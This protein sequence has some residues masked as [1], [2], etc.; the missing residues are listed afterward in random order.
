LKHTK[1]EVKLLNTA[2]VHEYR[3]PNRVADLS[4]IS[5]IRNR[6]KLERFSSVKEDRNNAVSAF[7]HGN[8]LNRDSYLQDDC[9]TEAGFKSTNYNGLYPAVHQRPSF[10]SSVDYNSFML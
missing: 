7:D 5:P 1:E 3:A 8:A 2:R 9:S 10:L 6:N 4:N